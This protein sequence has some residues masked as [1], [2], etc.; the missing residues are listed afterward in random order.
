M[1]SDCLLD[2]ARIHHLKGWKLKKEK[3]AI[4][5]NSKT[6]GWGVG[7]GGWGGGS[8]QKPSQKGLSDQ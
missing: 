4:S 7:G 8:Q 1:A 2:N 6:G 3:Q 5:E